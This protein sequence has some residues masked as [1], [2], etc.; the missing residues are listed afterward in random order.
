M[1]NRLF[2]GLLVI[3]MSI[4]ALWATIT[5]FSSGVNKFREITKL[6]AVLSILVSLIRPHYG[7]VL[8]LI[9]TSCLDLFK[10]LIVLDSNFQ[11]ID[12][13]FVLAYSPAVLLGVC[14]GILPSAS[15]SGS[16]GRTNVILIV[17]SVILFVGLAAVRLLTAEA[18]VFASIATLANAASYVVLLFVFPILF[19][20]AEKQCRLLRF[21]VLLFVPVAIYGLKQHFFGLASFER[22]YLE[23]GFSGESRHIGRGISFTDYRLNASTLNSAHTLSTMMM[24]LCFV[25]IIPFKRPGKAGRYYLMGWWS[26]LIAPLFIATAISTFTRAGW[27]SGLLAFVA[28]FLF[29][30]RV[31]VIVFYGALGS[32]ITCFF[33][34]PTVIIGIFKKGFVIPGSEIEN[35][36]FRTQTWQARLW[37]FE[38]L[39]NDSSLWTP[40]GITLDGRTFSREDWLTHDLITYLIIKFGYVPA[41][42]VAIILTIYL[43]RIHRSYFRCNNP[44]EQKAFLI[45]LAGAAGLGLAALTNQDALTVFPVNFY[46][47]MFVAM[48]LS[49]A[50]GGYVQP[51]GVAPVR[52]EENQLTKG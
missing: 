24:I 10:R 28:Y 38:N 45:A 25:V 46:F 34:F 11:Y 27:F 14:V 6:F 17:F 19:P 13:F 31:G 22:F 5:I 2:S 33:L 39:A 36:I 29:K 23:T 48:A 50:L 9:S 32:M 12:I 40:F 3:V 37:G 44:S 43:F 20:D 1:N 4:V 15:W 26:I 51:V 18:S 21:A 49:R 41:V 47:W 30:F 7:F 42:I 8:V 52:V 16:K 35:L